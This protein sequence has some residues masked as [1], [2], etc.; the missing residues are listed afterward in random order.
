MEPNNNTLSEYDI[1]YQPGSAIKAQALAEF[2]NEAML[3]END[4]EHWLLHA[5]RFCTLAGS[6]AEVVLTNP[7]GDELEYALCFNFKT[8]TNEVECETFIVG[9]RM[10]LDVG[11]KSLIAYPDSQL[12]TNL[13]EGEYEVKEERMK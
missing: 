9:I 13:V 5:D 6:G 2:V 1:S 7:K 11:A 10:A 4:E 3:V 12:M 8:S